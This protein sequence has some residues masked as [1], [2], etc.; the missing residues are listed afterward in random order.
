MP[1]ILFAAA[2]DQWDDYAPHLR[3]ALDQ[4]GL[5]TARVGPD[6][7]A[8]DVDYIVYSPNSPVQDFS[9][10]PRLK[11]VL[12]LWAGVETI[13]TR[14]DLPP[15]VPIARMVDPGM[16]EEVLDLCGKFDFDLVTTG[17]DD[18]LAFPTVTHLAI[19]DVMRD[20][21]AHVVDA[22]RFTWNGTRLSGGHA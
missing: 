14:P 5:R 10:F 11:A 1:N 4:A 17:H 7:P 19:Y 12:S 21:D 16:T 6:I 20:K 8:A 3:R 22:E 9:R 15:G 18:W 2:P 13:V